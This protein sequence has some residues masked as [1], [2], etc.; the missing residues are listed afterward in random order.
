MA[1]T[2][3]LA[4]SGMIIHIGK[5]VIAMNPSQQVA[6]LYDYD[7]FG[8]MNR[9]A[10]QGDTPT[11][12]YANNLGTAVCTTGARGYATGSTANATGTA[13]GAGTWL[14]RPSSRTRSGADRTSQTRPTQ[15]MARTT[16]APTSICHQ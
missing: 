1:G 14:A 8:G 3:P 12:P 11:H 16:Q 13:S 9:Q 7:V 5:P 10:Y 6:G 2:V 4:T 15:D